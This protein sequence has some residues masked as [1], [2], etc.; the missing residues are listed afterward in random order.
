MSAATLSAPVQVRTFR[1]EQKVW[2]RGIGF[3]PAVVK[4]IRTESSTFEEETPDGVGGFNYA[5]AWGAPV[6]EYLVYAQMSVDNLAWPEPWGW[7]ASDRVFDSNPD[8][9]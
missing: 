6:T 2:V 3:F 5:V 9:E 4:G 7:L 8:A 1:M